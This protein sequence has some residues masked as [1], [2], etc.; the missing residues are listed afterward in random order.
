V[1]YVDIASR[2]LLLTVFSLALAGKTSSRSAWNEF[3]ESIRAMAVI[4]RARAPMA[5]AATAA[6][7]AG[8]IVLA[9]IPLRRAGSA[10]FLLAAGLLGCLTVAVTMVVRRGAAVPCRCFGASQT[11]LGVPH[12]VRNLILVATALLGLAGSLVNGHFDVALCAVVAV[13]GTLLGLVMARWD[14]LVSLLRV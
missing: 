4:D 14:D 1:Q 9:L 13:F 3:V 5:A 6:A 8:V 2:L 11:P 10:A 12:V 7:E